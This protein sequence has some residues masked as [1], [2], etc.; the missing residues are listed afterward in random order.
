MVQSEKS[1]L[2]FFEGTYIVLF[3]MDEFKKSARDASAL[4][5]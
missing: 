3:S 4:S 2:A 5:I 1:L